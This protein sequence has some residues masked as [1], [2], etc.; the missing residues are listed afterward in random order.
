MGRVVVIGRTS[1]WLADCALAEPPGVKPAGITRGAP[2]RSIG[3]SAHVRFASV[4]IG[5]MHGDRIALKRE[6]PALRH[7]VAK[8]ATLDFQAAVAHPASAG[9]SD[10]E[11]VRG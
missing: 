6:Q 3:V 8:G 4:G 1:L 2:D 5:K 10:A 7:A 9:G 11:L